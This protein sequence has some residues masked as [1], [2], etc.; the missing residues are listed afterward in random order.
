[1][2]E[3]AALPPFLRLDRAGTCVVLD[4]RQGMAKPIHLGSPL[5][6]DED[7]ESLG[8]AARRGRHENQAEQASG[9]SL[10]PQMGVEV[11][12]AVICLRGGA[13]CFTRFLLVQAS[14]A[15]HECRL[16]FRDEIAAIEVEC[17]WRV[18]AAGLVVAD[19]RLTNLGTDPLVVVR[20]ASLALPVPSRFVA[21]TR[22]AGRWAA[23]MHAETVAWTRGVQVA[24]S[25]GG[26]PGFGG[27][28]WVMLSGQGTTES[29]GAVLG[30]HLAWSG[31]H[32]LVLERDADDERRLLMAARLDIG[33]AVLA[34]GESF[35]SPAALF[36]VGEGGRAALRQAFHR[37]ALAE[38]LP[39]VAT[40]SPRKV[41]LNTWEAL[42]F[43]HTLADLR[44]LA[45][46]AAQLGVE[47]FVL[48]DG[49]FKG[50]RDDTTSLGDWTVDSTVFPEGLAPLIRHVRSLGMDFGLWVEPEML[51]PDSDL[52]R[53]H[54]E[55]CLSVEGQVRPTQRHQWVL[56]L[57]QP[58]AAEHVFRCLEALLRNNEIAYLKW[59]HNRELAPRAGRAR[60]Q[61]LAHLALLDRLRAQY[62]QLEIET[63]ASGGGRVDFGTLARC[64]RFWAS[65]NNDPIE[66]LVINEGWFQFLPPRVA[67]NH[68]GPS[69][70]P[71][72]G[73]QSPMLFRARVAM[74][75]HMGVEADPRRMTEAE[76]SILAAHIACYRQWR[77]CLHAGDW[78]LP[79]GLESGMHGW[80]VVHGQRALAL[81][82]Q[83]RFASS[84]EVAPVRFPGRRA[85]ARY[86]VRLPEPWPEP[87]SRYLALPAN[88]REGRV[89]SGTA[90]ARVG[91]AL[92]LAHPDTA[93]LIEF[94][95]LP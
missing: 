24:R 79:E 26:R 10:L 70:N 88:W 15:G 38:V 62:P 54:P 67:G 22:H 69:P 84:H 35:Q 47:R 64:S 39:E 85:T 52:A 44:E 49:W 40:R 93:W 50:R 74:F 16:R 1:M 71:I 75:G 73:R 12:P 59:D 68:V 33:E 87:A 2:P 19:A 6:A 66:R 86:R 56:D 14:A 46:A 25:Q 83:T 8:D 21:V 36:H 82:A 63:C 30:A 78:W 4:L 32:E 51:S 43:R 81:L 5:P 20:L 11:T 13:E 77:E 53:E 95:E 76:R 89:L 23:E 61:A 72:T 60:A 34:A 55:W 42:Y 9:P 57:T 48:D 7:L 58:E 91:L 41:H 92:P 17:R 80:M 31:D 29:N 45:E 37:H 28:Q 27:G 65:D 18:S 94:E 90:L 3:A